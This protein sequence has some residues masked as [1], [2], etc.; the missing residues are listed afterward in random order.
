MST[1][2]KEKEL[3]LSVD[4]RHDQLLFEINQELRHASEVTHRNVVDRAINSYAK[5]R[6]T[7]ESKEYQEL[8]AYANQLLYE[9]TIQNRYVEQVCLMLTGTSRTLCSQSGDG[10]AAMETSVKGP[11]RSFEPVGTENRTF[12]GS[13]MLT[14]TEPIIDI[15]NNQELGTLT[16]WLNMSKL[17]KSLSI[18]HPS[19]SYVLTASNKTVIFRSGAYNSTEIQGFERADV[20]MNTEGK[21]FHSLKYIDIPGGHTWTSY[22]EASIS[23]SDSIF[24]RYRTWV[25]AL[26]IFVIVLSLGSSYLFSH[27]VSKPLNMLKALMNR[28]ERGDL[29]AYWTAKSSVAWMQLGDS[30]NQMLNRVEDLIK[31]VKRE[32]S[33]KK[34]AE[35]EALHYQLNPHFLYNTLN[36]IKWVAKIHKT[37]QISEVVS[38]LVRLLQ[39]SLG[40]KGE[41]ITL[42]EE[43]GLT[44]D[45][46][47]IQK[48]RYGDRIQIVT[49]L[50]ELTLGC[51][52][53]RMLLQPLVENAIIHGIE[54]SKG[55]GIIT[56]RTWLDRDLLFCQVDDNGVG[57]QVEEGSSGWTAISIGGG[58]SSGPILRERMS[59]IG[60]TH[61]REKIKLYY[62]PEYKMHIGSK[63]GEGTTIRMSLPIHHGEEWGK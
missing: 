36:T 28:A 7:A 17:W 53:P 6:A 52:V 37:P 29:R 23:K 1:A 48:F 61:I 9:Q 26:F 5:W 18:M 32:E 35:M 30:Y 46:M 47:E 20:R 33:L 13:Y 12:N 58:T 34:E 49:E 22:F 15:T 24:P 62:G 2:Y 44:R 42:R 27:Y 54:P 45:Y 8:K 25:A 31:Q 3:L 10:M 19:L 51:L 56:I 60:I 39:A 50:D 21:A 38:A 41:F 57:M 16:M 40:K 63:P 55:E 59:G 11:Y 14:Y 4:Q 43:I